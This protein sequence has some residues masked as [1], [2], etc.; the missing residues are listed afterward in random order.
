MPSGPNRAFGTGRRSRNVRKAWVL[1]PVL[2]FCLLLF[3]TPGAFAA[4]APDS[5]GLDVGIHV[6][7]NPDDVGY[8]LELSAF[9]EGPAPVPF[10]C[11]WTDNVGTGHTGPTWT[12]TPE[13]PGLLDVTLRVEMPSGTDEGAAV[14]IQI[15]PPP[16]LAATMAFGQVEENTPVPWFLHVEGGVPPLNVTWNAT[17]G[18]GAGSFVA[19]Q[20]GNYSEVL[21]F[22]SPGPAYVEAHVV[23]SLG[24]VFS[25][26][27]P[28]VTVVPPGLVRLMPASLV[29]EVGYPT[30]TT[31]LVA[32]GTPPFRWT[33]S[34]TL[35]LRP[36]TASSGAFPSDGLYSW[37]LTFLQAGAA[38]LNLSLLDGLGVPDN[39]TTVVT[40]VPPLGV[41]VTD[42]PAGPGDAFEVMLGV[43]GGVPPYAY[44]MTLSDG[45]EA[46]GSLSVPT[47]L[48]EAF[49]PSAPGV[50]VEHIDV[51][52]A[53]GASW[54]ATQQVLVDRTPDPSSGSSETSAAGVVALCV[55][56]AIAGTLA[57]FRWRHHRRAAPDSARAPSALPTVRSILEREQVLDRETLLLLGEEAGESSDA[58]STALQTLLQTGLVTEEAGPGS[59][60]VLRWRGPT[61]PEAPP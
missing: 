41:N 44:R 9:V 27:L 1:I 53:L 26:D 14:S 8:P 7:A 49:E 43:A 56:V 48:R 40:V 24:A 38:T 19:S 50:Y 5:G 18:G 60:Q 35:P 29:A 20:D 61:R 59:D 47:I 21:D 42:G 55:L 39:A 51:T 57:L 16:S 22:G 36:G 30:A 3:W 15:V 17:D 46:N 4:S 6:S 37:N 13:A 28:P 34:S 23:D 11:I 58:V 12:F 33:L 45:E 25:V 54:T 31:V 32:A 52:D 2:P 10:V